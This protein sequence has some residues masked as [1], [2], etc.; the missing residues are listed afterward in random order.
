MFFDQSH[1]SGQKLT[2]IINDMGFEALLYA[3]PVETAASRAL[4]ITMKIAHMNDSNAQQCISHIA[5][6][7]GILNAAASI[8]DCTVSVTYDCTMTSPSDIM[9]VMGVAGYGSIEEVEL[10]FTDLAKRTNDSDFDVIALRN[11]SDISKVSFASFM[12]TY[13]MSV[14]GKM[15]N[16][17]HEALLCLHIELYCLVMNRSILN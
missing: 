14:I 1:T 13:A 9:D 5:K 11:T 10:K 4:S 7:H 15:L 3:L 6:Q 17:K 12:G 8:K 16:N 2:D